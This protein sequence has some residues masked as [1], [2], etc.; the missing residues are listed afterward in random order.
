[1]KKFTLFILIFISSVLI[2][3]RACAGSSASVKQGIEA[4]DQGKYDDSIKNFIDAQ[5]ERPELP[6]LYYN[7]G[8]AAYKKQDYQSAL[9]NFMQAKEMADK[10]NRDTQEQN[11]PLKDKITFNLGN[12]KY[13]M[14]DLDGAIDHYAKIPETSELYKEAKENLEFVKQKI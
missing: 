11:S 2:E 8:S 14:G 5:L 6:E 12:T 13:R 7:I 10:A 3:N 4:Y 1:M 9:S